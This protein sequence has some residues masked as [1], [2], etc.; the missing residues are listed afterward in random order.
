MV[1]ADQKS[2]GNFKVLRIYGCICGVSTD[3]VSICNNTAWNGRMVVNNKL[4]KMWEE[5]VVAYLEALSGCLHLGNEENHERFE[6]A[7]PK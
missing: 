3:T 6:H 5:S 4:E 2:G 7:A 1:R